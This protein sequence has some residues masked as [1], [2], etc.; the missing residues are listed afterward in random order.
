VRPGFEAGDWTSSNSSSNVT[1]MADSQQVVGVAWFRRDLRIA[2]NRTLRRALDECDEVIPLF[3]VDDHFWRNAGANRR[4]FLAGCLADL[5]DQLGGRLVIRHGDPVEALVDLAHRHGVSRLYR[6]ADAGPAGQRRDAEVDD[7][8][9]SDVTSVVVDQPYTVP[10]GQLRTTTGEPFKMFTPYWRRWREL[11][12]EEPLRRASPTNVASGVRS[13]A[14]P[15]PDTPS[16]EAWRPEPGEPAAH[17]ALDRFLRRRIDRYGERR[18]DPATDATS[19]LGPYLKFGCIHPRQILHRLDL[20]D[21]DHET[22]ARQLAWRDFY[23][24]VLHAWPESAWKAFNPAVGQI[25]VDKG[26]LADERFAAW[27]AGRTGFPIVDAGM[28]QLVAEGFMHNRV[29][30]IVASFLVKDLHLDW[31]RGARYFLDHL[32][33]GDLASNNH[34]WQWAAGTGTDAAP[35]FRIFNP[36][37]QGEKFDPDGD[38]VRRWVP[39]LTDVS[40]EEIHA[41][42]ARA[43]GPP[44]YPPPIVDHAAEREESLRRLAHAT[45]R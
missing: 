4:W 36:Q 34:G 12:I 17:A 26:D 7:A 20:S 16:A 27:C 21:P 25:A 15:H 13:N 8:L 32:Y 30:M 39:E 11:S 42:H 23:A 22:F 45:G 18:D 2:D 35:Y 37:R 6:S 1:V 10:L 14:V 38:Y 3:V 5:D 40:A 33:D 29:R 24:D 43:D 9:R 44:D 31:T 19:R 28:R 41:P